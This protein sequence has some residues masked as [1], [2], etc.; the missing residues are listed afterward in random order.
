MSRIEQV[1]EFLREELSYLIAK[2]GVMDNALIT[3]VYVDTSPDLHYAKIIVS[4]LP[5]NLGGTALKKLSALSSTFSHMLLKHSRL[6]QIP[7]FRWM[8]DKTE[9]KAADLEEIFKEIENEK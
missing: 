3:I 7:K 8:L 1:N 6:R 2:E 4:V 5:D 9:K